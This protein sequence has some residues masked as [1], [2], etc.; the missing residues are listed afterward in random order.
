MLDVQAIARSFCNGLL[1][2]GARADLADEAER[3]EAA[4]E[5]IARAAL[6]HAPEAPQD[7]D[8]QDA[9]GRDVAG[10]AGAGQ[11][12]VAGAGGPDHLAAPERAA[13]AAR[14]DSLLAELRALLGP[15]A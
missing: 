4:L 3:L 6:T 1:A 7:A 8:T 12:G 15:A 11:A 10:Q 14:L 2:G 5:R 9:A 13:L